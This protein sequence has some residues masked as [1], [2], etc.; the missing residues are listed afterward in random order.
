[1]IIDFHTHLLPPETG[2]DP[3]SFAL[4]EPYFGYRMIDT[5]AR[6]SFHTWVTYREAVRHMDRD[7]VNLAVIQGW[8][9]IHYE[10]CCR[11]NN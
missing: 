1:M 7:D 5:P 8:P 3:Y 2:E 11:Q 6:K 9:F 4:S 10:S